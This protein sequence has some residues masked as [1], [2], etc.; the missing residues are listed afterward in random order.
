MNKSWMRQNGVDILRYLPE[1]LAKDAD[2]KAANDAESKEHDRI[3]LALQ[4]EL[5]QMFVK[6]AT[7]GLN[8]WEKFCGI[9]VDYNNTLGYE[10]RRARVIA[11]LMGLG[12]MTPERVT[13][14]INL[15]VENQGASFT[16]HYDSYFITVNIPGEGEVY[17]KDLHDALDKYLP[18]HI[19][20]FFKFVAEMVDTAEDFGDIQEQ[21]VARVGH[22]LEDD[23]PWPARTFDGSWRLGGSR[24]VNGSWP[25]DGSVPLNG[26]EGDPCTLDSDVEKL[27][28]T[29][30]RFP[31]LTDDFGTAGLALNG[32]WDFDGENMLGGDNLPL[33]SGGEVEV[34][35]GRKLNGTWMLDGGCTLRIDGSFC[36]D[37]THYIS[38]GGNHL[39]I[40]RERIRI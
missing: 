2:F 26:I 37:G 16:P 29:H 3:R 9:T 27:M 18:A 1:Y 10:R 32:A 22:M 28:L 33:D 6:T 24:M 34:R 4:D 35:K 25:I 20:Y 5:D 21:L 12:T 13:A 40:R 36:L 19:A 31:N 30:V 38:E 23:Y 7:W 17:I 39:E 11:Q 14:L 15:F 8:H